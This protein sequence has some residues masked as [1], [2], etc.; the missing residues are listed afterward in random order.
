MGHILFVWPAKVARL[1]EFVMT[2]FM[3]GH[4]F[5]TQIM[6]G[7]IFNW[8]Y[9]LFLKSKYSL[10]FSDIIC[11]PN[12]FGCVYT[13]PLFTHVVTLCVKI[14]GQYPHEPPNLR[15]VGLV[16]YDAVNNY[17]YKKHL[18]K[19]TNIN[20][21][22]PQTIFS[23]AQ[24]HYRKQRH[25]FI[26]CVLSLELKHTACKVLGRKSIGESCCLPRC[27]AMFSGSNTLAGRC[28]S[29]AL[30]NPAVAFGPE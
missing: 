23:P 24:R 14:G 4:E 13:F 8:K 5:Y 9:R 7:L 25:D 6:S 27:S 29:P 2:F 28:L 18:I 15:F 22:W 16:F 12:T 20:I 26:G 21:L 30:H 10:P 1:N 19:D 11:G 17:V 3:R